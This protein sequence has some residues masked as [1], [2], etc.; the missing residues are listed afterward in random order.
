MSEREF[1]SVAEISTEMNNYQPDAVTS[2]NFDA[3]VVYGCGY[4]RGFTL[5]DGSKN[6]VPNQ[7]FTCG[8]DNLW[9]PSET[10]MD[11]QC[12]YYVRWFSIKYEI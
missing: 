2:S 3:E 1:P 10:L 6:W 5:P 8:W 12:K 11:C 9:Q 4:A 7:T